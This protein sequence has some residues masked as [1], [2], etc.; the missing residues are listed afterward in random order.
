MPARMRASKRSLAL[1]TGCD[2][3]PGMD[4]LDTAD[5]G[6]DGEDAGGS[7]GFTGDDG[8]SLDGGCTGCCDEAVK[9]G[10]VESAPPPPHPESMA[11]ATP[12][13]PTF[14]TIERLITTDSCLFLNLSQTVICCHDVLMSFN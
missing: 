8:T 6:A 2:G 11:T 12:R 3:S 5:S 13:H 7:T 14:R 9:A 1:R 10:A 4:G